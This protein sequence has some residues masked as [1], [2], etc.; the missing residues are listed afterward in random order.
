MSNTFTY[1]MPAGI[2]GAVGRM[3][4]AT[5][6][7][8]LADASYP[9]L[10]FGIFLKLSSGKYRPLVSGDVA[11]SIVGLLVRPFPVQ[12]PI[13]S[14]AANEAVGGGLSS[15]S[16]INILKRGY[17]TVLVTANGGT[18]LANIAK[19]DQVYVRVTASVAGAVG[20]IEAG[21]ASG[22]VAVTGAYFLGGV[23]ASGYG[24]IAYNI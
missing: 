13:G 2:A 6:E 18:A 11:A 14:S 24:E 12:E 3:E 23:D 9:C 22:N 16:I 17:M 15:T 20:D 5:I 8:G 4:I 21:S 7:P 1:R 19:G 10:A